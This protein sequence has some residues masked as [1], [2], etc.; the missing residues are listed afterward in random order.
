MKGVVGAPWA[1]Q[2][3]TMFASAPQPKRP[4]VEQPH[5]PTV[6]FGEG[7]GVGCGEDTISCCNNPWL[8]NQETSG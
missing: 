6:L 2:T 5:G 1:S 4:F 7:K 3:Q 8:R